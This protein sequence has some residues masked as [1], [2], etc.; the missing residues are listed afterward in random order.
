ML[1]ADFLGACL[2]V[3]DLERRPVL[4]GRRSHP[5]RWD[6]W[7]ACPVFDS[8]CD[9]A[10]LTDRI[11]NAHCEDPEFGYR[12]IVD[13]V[14]AASFNVAER[15]VWRICSANCWWSSLGKKCGKHGK[16]LGSP[17][18]EDRRAS[19]YK[20]RVVRH[21]FAAGRANELWVGDISKHTT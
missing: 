9:E 7:C 4:G 20:H 21:E 14:R 10:L 19:T 12:F 16:K 13:E 3:A 2:P 17:V 5:V 11:F 18:R 15:T 6:R 8:E 1:K